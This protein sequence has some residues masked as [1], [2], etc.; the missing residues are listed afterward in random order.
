MIGVSM[1]EAMQE[2]RA[3]HYLSRINWQSMTAV[4]TLLPVDL[5]FTAVH[6]V[7]AAGRAVRSPLV[8]MIVLSVSCWRP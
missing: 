2:R 7:D 8:L 4:L 5:F 3:S 6:R 1:L